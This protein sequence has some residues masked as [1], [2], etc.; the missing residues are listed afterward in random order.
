MNVNDLDIFMHIVLII[1]GRKIKDTIQ[2]S[3]MKILKRR[4]MKKNITM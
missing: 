2:N 4:V 1:S 3:L